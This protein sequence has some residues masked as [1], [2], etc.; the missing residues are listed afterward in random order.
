MQGEDWTGCSLPAG[1]GFAGRNEERLRALYAAGRAEYPR[2]GLAF[3]V[4]ADRVLA[5]ADR[6]LPRAGGAGT[7]PRVGGFLDRVRGADL[8][9]AVACDVGVHGAW[10]SFAERFVPRLRGFLRR[11]GV[12]VGEAEE[13]ASALPGELLLPPAQDRGRTRIGTYDGS[14][15]LFAW[16]G[17]IALRR[18]TDRLRERSRDS[19]PNRKGARRGEGTLEAESVPAPDPDPASRVSDAETASRFEE[20]LRR[21]IAR[22]TEREVRAFVGRFHEGYSQR[23]IAAFLGVGEPRVS[24]LVGAGVSKLRTAV[25]Q[26][27][28]GEV[29]LEGFWRGGV[30]KELRKAVSRLMEQPPEATDPPGPSSVRT[31]CSSPPAPMRA[32][33]TRGAGSISGRGLTTGI[34][35]RGARPSVVYPSHTEASTPI[36][37]AVGPDLVP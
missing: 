7:P 8:F 26:G 33:S 18:W 15:P 6:R 37:S 9:L 31:R 12:P 24:R 20:A 4:F 21:G 35:C 14:T 16:L 23:E 17:R 25:R 32:S 10:E 5:L 34:R 3:G 22:L 36:A 28:D 30:W 27:L 2:A 19:G 1:D 29:R 11:H 13:V